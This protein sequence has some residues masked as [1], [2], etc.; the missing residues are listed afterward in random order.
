MAKRFKKVLPHII[1]EDQKGFLPGRYIGEN[2]R[3]L[4]D[5]LAYTDVNHIPG[6]LLL[7]DFEKAFDSVAWTFIDKCMDFF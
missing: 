2:L 4:Y 6:M 3:M 5:I 7:I 1:H